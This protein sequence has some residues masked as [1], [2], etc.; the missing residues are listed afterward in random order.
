MKTVLKENHVKIE[1]V[2]AYSSQFSYTDVIMNTQLLVVLTPPSIYHKRWGD[3]MMM[4]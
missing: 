4:W 3:Q 2:R 1:K